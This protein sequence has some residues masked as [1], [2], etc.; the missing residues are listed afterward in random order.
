MYSQTSFENY[1]SGSAIKK[2]TL[3]LNLKNEKLAELT[4]RYQK[5]LFQIAHAFLP[6]M[7]PFGRL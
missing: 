3:L 4:Q 6:I 1:V 2:E 7:K 5:S